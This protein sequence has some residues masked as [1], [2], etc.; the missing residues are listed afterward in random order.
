M[1]KQY[2]PGPL[3]SRGRGLDTRLC[4]DILETNWGK[5]K[6]ASVL[7]TCAYMYIVYMYVVAYENTECISLFILA[8][9][10]QKKLIV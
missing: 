10:W 7:S 5:W 3:P 9:D 1:R 8:T 4:A 6:E 2:I